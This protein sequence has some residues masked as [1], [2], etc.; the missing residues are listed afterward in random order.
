MSGTLWRV[1]AMNIELGVYPL[2]IL[3]MAA[4]L[5]S[6]EEADA[7]HLR[8]AAHLAFTGD[9]CRTIGSYVDGSLTI[10]CYG[11]SLK[12]EVGG[13]WAIGFEGSDEIDRDRARA[14]VVLWRDLDYD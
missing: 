14:G 11:A 4:R 8:C 5:H 7:L 1:G 9:R 13:A 6:G 2:C 12:L 3:L 10:G